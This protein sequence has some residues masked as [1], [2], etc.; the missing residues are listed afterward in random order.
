MQARLR[1]FVI[2]LTVAVSLFYLT[3]R[4]TYTLNLATTYSTTISLALIFCRGVWHRFHGAVRLTS[5]GSA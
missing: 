4:V 2:L 3:Y 1:Q 5:L